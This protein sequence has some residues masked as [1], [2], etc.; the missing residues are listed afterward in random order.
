MSFNYKDASGLTRTAKASGSG[1]SGSPD[2]PEVM[3]KYGGASWTP[4]DTI[5][6][7]ADASSATD[8]SAAPTAAQKIVIDDLVISAGAA[9]TVT[10]QEE[11]SGTVLY[12]F[13]LP[14]NTTL[15]IKPANGR[16]LSTANK[17]VQVLASGAGNLFC[18][19]SYH[20]TS[21]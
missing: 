20:S 18:H 7:T 16:K 15:Q 14:A 19:C 12:K 21:D 3:S 2:I 11:T 4:G 17:K 10:V 8:L 9:L 1:T 5:V 6:N 13:Y